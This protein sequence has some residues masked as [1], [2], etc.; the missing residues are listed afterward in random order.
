MELRL[1]EKQTLVIVKS[2][3]R[4]VSGNEGSTGGQSAAAGE[5]GA[6][7]SKGRR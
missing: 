5:A 7:R 3:I 2:R 1:G 4:S 6:G